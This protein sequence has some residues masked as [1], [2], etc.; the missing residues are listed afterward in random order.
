MALNYLVMCPQRDT[1]S[2]LNW[3]RQHPSATA[4]QH[5]KLLSL[6]ID[7]LSKSSKRQTTTTQAM[8]IAFDVIVPLFGQV[9]HFLA[10]HSFVSRSALYEVKYAL[11]FIKS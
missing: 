10:R 1:A 2:P 3:A 6:D 8:V 9:G 5:S 4:S 11:V 7:R